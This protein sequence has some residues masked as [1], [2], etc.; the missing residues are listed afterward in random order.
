MNGKLYLV[1]YN[2][3][4][5]EN[6]IDFEQTFKAVQSI[7]ALNQIFVIDACESGQANDIVSAVYDSKASVLAK[8]S[9]VHML[10]ATTKGT[11]AFESNDPN[12][13]N[14]V[15]THR[16]LSALRNRATDINRDS[17]ITVKEVSKEL[18]KPQSNADFQYPVIR[19]VGSD[20]RLEKL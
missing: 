11:S 20:V 15:F 3:R 4:N 14:G 6:W 2:N 16:V 19:N 10:L 8:S 9:G 18:R 7:K 1:P 17:F 12:I 5:G 13:K